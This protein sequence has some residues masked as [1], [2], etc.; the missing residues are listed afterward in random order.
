VLDKL[1]ATSESRDNGDC[2]SVAFNKL[3]PDKSPYKGLGVT[4]TKLVPGKVDSG[5]A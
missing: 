1:K 5:V 3:V 4:L 2:S